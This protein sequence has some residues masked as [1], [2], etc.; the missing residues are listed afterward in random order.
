VPSSTSNFDEPRP[1]AGPWLK[2]WLLAIAV[3]VAMSA[4]AERLT[5]SLGFVPSITDD[6]DLWCAAFDRVAADDPSQIV[7]IGASRFQLGIDLRE[8]AREFD[9]QEP[10]QLSVDGSSC[11]PVLDHLSR[12]TSFRGVVI[13]DISCTKLFHG[14]E[15][16]KGAQAEYLCH[17]RSRPVMNA[18]NRSL[19]TWIQSQTTFRQLARSRTRG[20]PHWLAAGALPTPNYV[21]MDA[22]R[23]RKANYSNVELDVLERR[24]AARRVLPDFHFEPDKIDGDINAVESMVSRIQARGGRV[25]FVR[26]PTTGRTAVAEEEH[27]P[28]AKTWDVMASKSRAILIHFADYPSLA[29]CDCPDESHLDAADAPRFTAA[30][31]RIIRRELGRPTIAQRGQ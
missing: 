2:T 24:L 6:A 12:Q 31:A 27:T 20:G 13:V 18:F 10:I 14:L 7:L 15:S 23:S 22:E 1:P 11:I 4:A 9:G 5:R 17:Y 28:R 26:M 3:V 19:V 8:I 30:L 25:V 29:S 16:D 21:T